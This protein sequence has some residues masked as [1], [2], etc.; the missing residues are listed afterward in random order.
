VNVEGK[1]C[2][3]SRIA[4]IRALEDPSRILD[5]AGICVEGVKPA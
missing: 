3:E 2:F 4:D 5:G 1:D